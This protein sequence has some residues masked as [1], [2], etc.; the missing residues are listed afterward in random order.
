MNE[1]QKLAPLNGIGT[2]YTI[3]YAHPTARPQIERLMQQEQTILLDIRSSPYSR[4]ALWKKQAL[5]HRYGQRY[6]WERRLG[7]LKYHHQE[8]EIELAEGHRQ[9]VEHVA[10][11]LFQ[12]TSLILLCACKDARTCHRTLVAKLVQDAVQALRE[13]VLV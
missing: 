6:R 11:M 10:S 9:A 13:G 12:G 2:L 7:N 4:W 1:Q 3:G 8:R 5:M